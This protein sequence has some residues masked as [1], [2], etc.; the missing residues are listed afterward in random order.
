MKGLEVRINDNE[1]IIAVSDSLTSTFISV[2]YHNEKDDISIRGIDS[3]SHHL[4]WLDREIKPGDRIKIRTVERET[5]SVLKERFP[6]DRKQMKEEY[7]N[8]KKQ[9][10]D[11][12]LL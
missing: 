5:A 6:S 4:S 8:L 11:K 7:F 10:E 2:G 1:P 3:K 12:G 9:L